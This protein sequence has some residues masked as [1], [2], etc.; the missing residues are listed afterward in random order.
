MKKQLF[1][2]LAMVLLAPWMMNAQTLESY[3]FTTGVDASKWVDMTSATQILSPTGSDGLAST[4]QT[5]GF[6]FPFGASSYTQYSVNTDGNLRLGST[7]TGTLDY[8]TPFNSTNANSNSPKINAFGCDGYGVSGSHY[9]KSLLSVNDDGDSML[10][11]EFCTGTFTNATRNNLYKW[12]IQLHTNGNIDIVF[13]STLP[14]APAAAH[15]CGICVNSSDGWVIQSSSNSAIH[16]TAGSTLTNAANTWFDANRYYTFI[17]PSNISCPAPTGVTA[18]NITAT[19]ATLSW[20]AGGNETA[21]ELVVDDEIY[22]PTDT[23]YTVNNLEGNTI[24]DVS[25]RAICGSG[26]TSFA[27]NGTFR[28]ACVPISTLPYTNDFEDDPA[29]SSGSVAYADALPACWTRINDATGTYNYYP[30]ISSTTT[31]V[32]SG[33]HGMYWYHYTAA[34][35]ANNEYAVLPPIDPSSIDITDLTLAFYAKTTAATYH[36][37]PIIGVMTDPND[38]STFTPVYSFTA[39][40]IT[41]TWQMFAVSLASYTGTGNYIAIKWPR[42][43]TTCNLAIDDIYLTDQWCDMPGAITSTATSESVTLTWEGNGG[44]SFT[45][46]VGEDTIS[47][48]TDTTYTF[49][50][51]T[52]ATVYN[53][54]VATECGSALSVFV[55]GSIQTLCV[56]ITEFPWSENFD[57]LTNINQLLVC[58]SRYSGLYNDTAS[59]TL[60]PATAGWV[61]HSAHG[62]EGS[63][64]VKV[65][66]F[67]TGCKYWLMSPQLE[68]SS[69]MELSFEYCLTTYNSDNPIDASVTDDRFIVFA[70]VD[71]TFVPLAKWGNDSLRDDYSYEA[72]SNLASGINF[73]L[74]QFDGQTIRIAF[75]GESTVSGDDND[76]HVDNVY[77]GTP[78]SCQR[79]ASVSVSAVSSDGAT[80]T[81][82]DPTQSGSYVM[83]YY[84]IGNGDTV[85]VTVTDTTFTLTELP[86]NTEYVVNVM[87]DCGG[88]LTAPRSTTFRTACAAIDSLPWIEDFDSYAATSSATVIPCWEH[89]GGG[90]VNFYTTSGAQLYS[91][92]SLRFYPSGSTAGNILVLPVFET[93][94]SDLEISLMS[95]PEGTSSGSFSVGYVTNPTDASSFVEVQEYPISHFQVTSG[96]TVSYVLLTNTFAGAPEGARIAL[97]HNVSSTSWYWFI[98]SIN[99]HEAPLCLPVSQLAATTTTN[100]VTLTWNAAADQTTWLVTGDNGYSAVVTDTTT[101]IT[102]L[103]ANTIYEFSVRAL[104]GEGDTSTV[105]TLQT[106]TEC[107][108]LAT[109]PFSEDF[110]SYPTY[111]SS[112]T[113]TP[114]ISCWTRLNN[115]TTYGGVP[116]VGG[117][118]YN[119]TTGGSKGLYWYASTGTTYGDY[120]YIILPQIDIE[121]LNINNMMLSFWAKASS[122]SYN[123]VFHVGVM[124]SNTDTAF[125]VIDTININGNT[126]WTEYI[127]NF[128]SYTGTG[129]YIAIRALRPSSTWYAYL[130]DITLDV[131]PSCARVENLTAID[132]SINSITVAW[133]DTSSNAGW[134]VEYG[135]NAFVPGTGVMTPIHVTDTFCIITGLDSATAYHVYVYPDCGTDVFYRH[136]TFSTLAA[137]PATVPYYCNFEAAG[138]NGWDLINGTQVNYWMVGNATNN[139]GSR[140]LYIT[141]DGTANAYTVGTAAYVFASRN[142][143]L[144]AGNYV[145]SYDWKA[146]GESSFDFIRAALVPV[147]TVLIPGDYSGFDNTSAMPEGGIALDGANRLNLQGT[148]WNTRV[149][150]FDIT[151][152]GT[153]KIVFLWRNDNSGGAQP[154][155]AIDNVSLSLSTCPRVQ[156]VVSNVSSSSIDLA[157]TAGGTETSWLVTVDNNTGTVVTTPT[158]SVTGLATDSIYT[159]S[160]RPICAAGDTG[161]AVTDVY[162]TTCNAVTLPYS[163]NFDTYTT[164]TTAATGVH[165]PCW[166]YILTGTSTYQTATYQPQVYYSSSYAHSGSYSYRLYGQGYHMLPPMPVSLDTLQLTFWD[167]TTSASYGLEVGVMEGNTF[168]PL[169]TISTPNSTH[170]QH[171]VYFLNYSGSSRIIAFRNWYTTGTTIYYSTHYID[172]VEVSYLPSC[173]PVSNIHSVSASTSSITV[174]WDDMATPSQWQI[175]YGVNGGTAYNTV[176]VSSRPATITGLD[177]LTGYEISIRPI[178]SATDTGAWSQ[179]VVLSTEICDNA[180]AASTGASTGSGYFTPVNNYYK[181]SLTETIIDSAELSGIGDIIAIAY[182]YAHTTATTKKDSVSIWLQPTDK[183]VFTA[184]TD[185]VLLDSSIAV[186]V[187]QGALNCTQGW[188]Y[189]DLDTTYIWNGHSNLLVI[190]D[191]NSNQYDGSAYSFRTSACTGYKTIAWYSDSQNPDPTSSTYSGTKGYYQYRA[192]MKLVSCGMSC[193]APVLDTAIVGETEVSLNWHGSATDYEVAAVEGSWNNPSTGTMVTGSSYTVTGL[194]PGTQY[195]IGV[196]AVCGDDYYSEWNV[197]TVT[198]LEHPCYDPSDV[199]ATN[200]TF[201]G[202]TIA[203]T[204]GEATQTNFELHITAAGVDTLVATTSN[205]CTVTGLPAA[206]AYTVTVRAVCGENNYSEWSAPATFT[207]ATCQMVEGVR[208][209][210]T[211]ATTATIT[212]TANGS[213]SYEVAYGITGTS[214]ENCRRLTANTNSIT[215]NGLDEATTYDVYVRSVCT[216]GV[217]SDWSDVVTFETQDVAIDDVD[218]ASISLYPNPASSTVTLTGIEGDATVTVVDMNGRELYTQ[219]I[220]QSSNQTITIDVTGYAQGAYFVRITGER[221]NAIRK[222]IV[223]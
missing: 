3:G 123:P 78:V 208:A 68:V 210:A 41:T 157:W 193:N 5:I 198:T 4:V 31:Y 83:E 146:Q 51:L 60:T 6:S 211:T 151:T 216:A 101:T 93:P 62:M 178:C 203:W 186:K 150:E 221:V 160:I 126:T 152:P 166:Q 99:V 33:S 87:T 187:Y 170:T 121:A 21:W 172:D 20:T 16:F 112:S 104:C 184:N 91:G 194:T 103:N 182:N 125:T 14:T 75:Y 188:N 155:A 132:A 153:Y 129:S 197:M 135:P 10:V 116:Y 48:I 56:P 43:G 120:M 202:A 98:D 122:S 19:S 147:G 40:E 65:N 49:T 67:G 133:S 46:Y 1:L 77:I 161:Y 212:W 70:V 23:T 22:Y 54:G 222:L 84:P 107:G 88:D 100:S 96:T 167:Y 90:Y 113:S 71:T 154:P 18:S 27:A 81:W 35:Y 144:A 61:L 2:V 42:P 192:T 181:Y 130:D 164:S 45:V 179:P 145:C 131:T 115:G 134:N 162:H 76:L 168:V 217:T 180:F 207:T 47:G 215:I 106:R 110:E 199:T 205:P 223:K 195:A 174:D 13:P 156:D 137:S 44:S 25:V 39:T 185:L 201:T 32:H 86:S 80:I 190:I 95:K 213:S 220:K 165:V 171:T 105:S 97:R 139:G 128:S 59:F 82:S 119:H 124:N 63:Q 28:T 111:S 34:A 138:P 102:G 189:F 58:W 66:I 206:T 15:Q 73:S 191:D 169:Q 85:T 17:H 204:A 143:T 94:I 9:V 64:H 118:S 140:S 173:P 74:D 30:Y 209:S 69:G 53:Y 163:E 29:Y 136:A 175:R 218:N 117:S 79:P 26:D 52:P 142:V 127:T 214:R 176:T 196:R 24:Y 219:A 141:N 12:Q 55:E 36:P 114:F 158:F 200:P 183:S 159:V 8:T 72:I 148:T 108:L 37:Q 89:L 57:S 7:A 11:V 92:T 38:T 109:L 50:E 149:E 177:T